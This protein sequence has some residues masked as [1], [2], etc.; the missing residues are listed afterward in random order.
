MSCDEVVLPEL[1]K[2]FQLAGQ[3]GMLERNFL[4]LL[5]R[6]LSVSVSYLCIKTPKCNVLKQVLLLAHDFVGL[7]LGCE[8]L[9][10]YSEGLTRG[11]SCTCSYLATQQELDGFTQIS[12]SWLLAGEPWYFTRPV[13]LQ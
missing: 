11:H 5:L 10:R 4:Q 2:L 12:D 1:Y 7:Q 3:I 9:N 13:I 6:Y 8:Q